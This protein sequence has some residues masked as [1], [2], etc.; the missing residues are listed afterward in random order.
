MLSVYDGDREIRFTGELLGE[1]SS[2]KPGKNR[3]I[4]MQIFRTS[5]GKY[6]VAGCGKTLIPGEVE[7]RWAHV[8]EEP[9]GAVE[10][11]HLYDRDGVRYMTRTARE[12]LA[13]ACTQDPRLRDAFMVQYVD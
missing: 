5:G 12:A 6:I 2:E 8:C 9:E 1:S 4:A 10:A 11:L 13:Q 7:R 3:W